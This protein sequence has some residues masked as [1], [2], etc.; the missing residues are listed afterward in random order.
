MKKITYIIFFLSLGLVA[1]DNKDYTNKVATIDSTIATLYSVISGD[2]GESRNWEL[3]KHL[4]RQDAKLI[5]IGEKEGK[6]TVR[7]MSADDYKKTAGTWLVENGF[8]EV[9]INRETQVF[10]NLA[11]VF[12]TYESYKTK[13]D[14]HPFMRGINSIQLFN[15]GKRWWILNLYWQQESKA[16]QIP[17]LYLPNN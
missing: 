8:H 1:Q 16:N 17:D 14:D 11:H 4:F 7:Y 2:K 15:D 12:S 9:E 13:D 10:G 3:F 5:P 6:T